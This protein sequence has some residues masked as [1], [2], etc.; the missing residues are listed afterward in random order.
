MS[1]LSTRDVVILSGVACRQAGLALYTDTVSQDVLR[2]N[3][4]QECSVP[5][6]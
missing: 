3:P 5:P 2:Y 1:A 6:V 4:Q